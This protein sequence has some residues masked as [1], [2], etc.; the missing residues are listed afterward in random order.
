MQRQIYRK[1]VIGGGRGRGRGRERGREGERGLEEE[2]ETERQRERE[3]ATLLVAAEYKIQPLSSALDSIMWEISCA[4][5]VRRSIGRRRRRRRR[6]HDSPTRLYTLT[7]AVDGAL[8]W[9]QCQVIGW[10]RVL[11]GEHRGVIH[12]RVSV[13][14]AVPP[15]ISSQS[16]PAYQS[17]RQRQRNNGIS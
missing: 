12:S 5:V 13:H 1:R 7:S 6:G 11:S 14:V 17:D 10:D 2:E 3:M 9:L 16:I 15:M 8:A 4:R